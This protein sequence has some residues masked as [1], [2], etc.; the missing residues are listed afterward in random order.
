MTVRVSVC[1]EK[2]RDSQ[3]KYSLSK[4]VFANRL[5]PRYQ[6]H[7]EQYTSRAAVSWVTDMKTEL[8]NAFNLIHVCN[9]SFIEKSEQ[10]ECCELFI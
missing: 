1:R 6:R 3:E 9:W 5:L 10:S 2:K 4:G 8:R 7:R